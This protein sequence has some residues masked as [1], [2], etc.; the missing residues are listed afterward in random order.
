MMMVPA[1]KTKKTM[2]TYLRIIFLI[3]SLIIIA[4]YAFGE[5]LVFEP[6]HLYVYR[7]E[8]IS[9]YDADTVKL[10]IDL[11]MGVWIR[12]TNVRLYGINAPEVRGKERSKGIRAR[13]RLRELVQ[14][15][16]VIIRTHK[17][18]TGK[19]G[20][21]LCELYIAGKDGRLININDLLIAEGH[22]VE[23]MKEAE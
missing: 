23:Y 1:W 9:V 21:Y 6:Q 17:D 10:D 4:K 8:V 22:A 15:Q 11:G 3:S 5:E 12:K 14:G 18:R 7:A 2:K 19:F 20:R 13:D 16:E